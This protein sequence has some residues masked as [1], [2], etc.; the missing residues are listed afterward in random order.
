MA[1]V[2]F[3]KPGDY[4][5][6]LF[7]ITNLDETNHAQG[8]HRLF[9]PDGDVRAHPS[10]PSPTARI[11]LQNGFQVDALCLSRDQCFPVSTS[12]SSRKM[13]APTFR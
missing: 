11:A 12:R 8:E 2:R 7:S 6:L 13:V 10:R 9:E 1:A 5:P 4:E 3:H